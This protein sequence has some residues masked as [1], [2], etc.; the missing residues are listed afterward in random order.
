MPCGVAKKLKKMFPT[1]WKPETYRS[2]QNRILLFVCS[3][4]RSCPTL[5][6]PMDCKLPGSSVHGSFRARILDWVAISYLRQSSRPRDQT[7]T[8]VFGR[9]ILWHCH[10]G[11]PHTTFD[12]GQKTMSFCLFILFMG[13]SGQEHWSGLPSP[14]PWA[15]GTFSSGPDLMLGK[16]EGRRRG[17]QQRTRWLDG[18][19]DSMDVS[20]SKLR[21]IVK[22]REA[23]HATFCGVAESDTT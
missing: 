9:R 7:C 23:W 1:H 4:S 5:C 10:L 18:I 16:V 21:E 12:L 13:F 22:D 17:E 20:L 14:S 8:L 15:T 19:T 3:V 2:G 11:S 6:D